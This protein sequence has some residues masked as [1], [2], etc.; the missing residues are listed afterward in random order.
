MIRMECFPVIDCLLRL[1]EI[2]PNPGI[3][4]LLRPSRQ[5]LTSNAPIE[6]AHRRIWTILISR[7]GAVPIGL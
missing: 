4:R 5:R 7:L 2:A 6:T 3:E 1:F